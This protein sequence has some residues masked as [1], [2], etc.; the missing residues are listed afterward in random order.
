[1]NP[2]RALSILTVDDSQ[3]TQA[4][5]A[6][7]LGA[8]PNVALVGA[9]F[10]G[11]SGITAIRELRP[12]VVLLDLTMPGGGGTEVLTTI[13]EDKHMPL[14][15]VN[16]LH[17]EPF[18]RERCMDLGAH[19]FNDK[20]DGMEKITGLIARLASG[21]LTLKQAKC[22]GMNE[23]LRAKTTRR[24]SVEESHRGSEELLCRVMESSNDCIKVLGLDG[25]LLWMN[26]RGQR[27]MEVENPSAIESAMWQD[28]WK[29][30]DHDAALA[31][32]AAARGNGVG[33]FT[34]R[35][36]TRQGTEKWWDVVITP[37]LDDSGKPER[38][39]SVSRDATER[40]LTEDR[41]R[42]QARMLDLAHDAIIV[43]DFT[44]QKILFWNK[45]AERLYGWTEE[46]ALGKPVGEL[47]FADPAAVDALSRELLKKDEHRSDI[48]HVTRDGRHLIIE[49]SATL[50]RDENGNPKSVLA[51]NTDITEKKKIE[52]LFLRAQ[53]LES[54]GTLASGLAHDLNNIFAPILMSLPLL[55]S[56]VNTGQNDGLIATVESSAERGAQIVRQVLRFARG[57]GGEKGPLQIAS[58][59]RE[60]SRIMEGTFPKNIAIE[61]AYAPDLWPIIGD[62]TQV[63]QVLLNLCVN[64]RDA[65]PRGGTL[66]M[67]ASN[68]HVDSA[69]AATLP[70]VAPGPFVQINVSDTG[71]GIP[72]E[73]VGRIFEPFFTTKE[74]SQG[75]GL[76][77][78]TVQT[79]VKNH[80]GVIKV[81]TGAGK[82]TTFHIFLPASPEHGQ[83]DEARPA[84]GP[85]P[86]GHGELVLL[87]DDEGTMRE[88]AKIA[89]AAFGYTVMTAA[90]GNEALSVFSKHK[91]RIAAV[92]TDVMMPSMGGVAL[93][94]AL[95]SMA[96]KL[97][98]IAFTGSGDHADCNEL[99]SLDVGTVLQ[100]PFHADTLLRT[101]S[102]LI[103]PATDEPPHQSQAASKGKHQS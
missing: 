89:L 33:S 37:I 19:V 52:G 45:G 90:D 98:I 51:I 17:A 25:R 35:C 12:D 21:T 31:A 8:I 18:I 24:A 66:R 48:R 74:S 40:K 47:I 95:R 6:R 93:A 80:G 5:L 1:M 16:T 64:A 71:E 26:A 82:G 63:H 73:I 103:H 22:E 88:A 79:I 54:I 36:A 50:M 94:R 28:F 92:I 61:R 13:S 56:D 91:A 84:Q 9:A 4:A 39:L 20:A 41:L 60:L 67:T 15:I 34:G 58:L 96:P 7:S 43:R 77:L 100:K 99:A 76:G 10:T 86:A 102:A 29:G 81:D 68:L 53:R 57:F 38:L 42:E 69:S 75:T 32:L 101:V 27:L 23:H 85:I 65:M 97:P 87:V 14:M 11:R 44:T 62:A 2:S 46:E 83:A 49:G 72:P 59:V 70:G 3:A 78:S 55:R 30:A